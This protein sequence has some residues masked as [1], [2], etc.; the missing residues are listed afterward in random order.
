MSGSSATPWTVVCQAF[1]SMGFP[2]QEY[3]SGLPFPSPGDLPTRDQIH[4][5]S[6]S[7]IAGEFFTAESSGKPQLLIQ[8]SSVQFS[9]SVV[10]NSC[11]PMDCSPPGSSVHGI[12]QARILEWVAISFSSCIGGAD[13]NNPQ[14]KEMQKRHTD[15]LRRPYK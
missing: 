7:W 6:V 2:R 13:Q 1:L 10:S 8:F 14:E 12:L 5:S 9:R 4:I 15:C 3:W 11:N